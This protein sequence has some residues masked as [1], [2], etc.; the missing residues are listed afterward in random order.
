MPI[1]RSPSLALTILAATLRLAAAATPT[2]SAPEWRTE[3]I[4]PGGGG[5]F[6][7]L[8]IDNNGNAH[9]SYANESMHE[10]KYGFWDHK[11]R[12]WFT[13]VVDNRS[14]GFASMAL[15][16]QQRPHISYLNY[17]APVIKYAHWDGTWKVEELATRATLIEYYTSI[18][19][20][21]NDRPMISFYEILR[22]G[23]Q[24]YVLHLRTIRRGQ[25]AWDVNLVDATPGSGKFNFLGISPA[26][27]V[28]I[29]YADV[30]DEY[31]SL[32]FARW[33]GSSWKPEILQGDEGRNHVHSVAYAVGKDGAPHISFTDVDKGAVRYA[34]T[35]HGRWEM[36]TVGQIG[37][38]AFP[39]RNG[40]TLDEN[41][42]PYMTW[43]DTWINALKFARRVDGKW[44]T[45]IIDG[46]V[47]GFTSS[48]QVRNGEI[49]ITY[50]DA[51][52]NTLKSARR[53]VTGTAET[54][55]EPAQS[56]H[57]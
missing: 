29:A 40:I 9:V 44:V 36:E 33:N 42:E 41:G 57:Q 25:D 28:S 55:T 49:V 7:T 21:K 32:R 20:D 12:K 24:D 8:L 43:V 23:S 6:S 47:S 37:R 22:P 46:V 17:G 26:G 19:L 3:L 10:L 53:S 5:K 56:A 38:E 48:I 34:T 4:D 45:E 13:M 35:R 51:A 11:L 30:K 50:Y 15:D 31:A 27:D 16:S 39:D 2:A 52:S 1:L 54:A 14:M 18:I